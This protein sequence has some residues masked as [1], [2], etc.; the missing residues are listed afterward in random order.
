M[1]NEIKKEI[2]KRCEHINE[3][4][5]IIE[6]EFKNNKYQLAYTDTKINYLLKNDLTLKTMVQWSDTNEYIGQTNNSILPQN[7]NYSVEH[8]IDLIS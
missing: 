4:D 1:I 5:G 7:F 2:H 6:F 8:F 3:Y